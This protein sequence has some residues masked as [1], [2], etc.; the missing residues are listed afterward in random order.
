MLA[1]LDQSV[2]DHA[3]EHFH[4][5]FSS[6]LGGIV[7]DPALMT[8]HLDDHMIHRGHAVFDTCEV[9][10]APCSA[11][12]A[13]SRQPAG[14]PCATAA[15]M[16]PR[17][18]AVHAA[19]AAAFRQAGHWAQQPDAPRPSCSTHS[20]QASTQVVK[21]HLYCMDQ[22]FRRFLNSAAMAGIP[23]SL[24]QAQMYR[25]IMETAAASEKM[26]CAPLRCPG[27]W[28]L[29]HWLIE[30]RSLVLPRS[31]QLFVSHGLSCSF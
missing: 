5:F 2:H 11:V 10:S 26:D 9:R 22:H 30:R 23:L 17:P 28:G 8:V 27:T 19:L 13:A 24:T 6:E 31:A 25:A 4:A 7:I 21:G 14:C 3:H 16:G 20:Q 12:D 1:A 18:A 29:H 15:R